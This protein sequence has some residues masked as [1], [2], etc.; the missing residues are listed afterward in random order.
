MS[1]MPLFIVGAGR[2]GLE[3]NSYLLDLESRGDSFHLMGYIDEVKPRGSAW[4][5]SKILGGMD[6]FREY[7]Q[8][9]EGVS[10]H[11]IT[12]AGNNNDRRDLVRKVESLGCGNLVH[13]T[14]RHPFSSIGREVE[15]GA[16]TSF[17]PGSIVTTRV[18]IGRHV[19]LNVKA[20]VSHDCVIGDYVNLNPGV[21][22]CGNVTVG[23]GSYIGAGATV[24]NGINVGEW[25]VVG[26]GAAVIRDVPPRVT[27]V[28]VPARIIERREG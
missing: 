5:S 21:V 24:M 7:L 4:G 15:I 22:L 2:H 27:V 23:E 9:H 17:A 3:L 1:E 8:K 28:G 11:Y 16:G 13:A 20:S 14:L 25:A 18:K 10:F 19:I 12:A 26:A 6:E